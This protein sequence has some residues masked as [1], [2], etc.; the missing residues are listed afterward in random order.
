MFF[1]K[2]AK[3]IYLWNLIRHGLNVGS[4]L[5]IE[6]GANIDAVFPELITIGDNVTLAK[7]VYILSHDGSTKKIIGYTRVGRV[8]IGDNVFI[9]AKTIVL[10]GVTIGNNSI[11]GAGSLVTKS[12]S[13]NEVWL[14]SPA[15]Y[16]CS[17]HEFKAK[18]EK[19]LITFG[20]PLILDGKKTFSLNSSKKKSFFEKLDSCA[21]GFGFIE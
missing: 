8:K 2:I 4:N 15:K 17:L 13:E 12:I 3:K 7:D 6:K 10:P 1:D 18:N 19:R 21:G 14:G 9:G 5:Q 20:S 11:V 16:F